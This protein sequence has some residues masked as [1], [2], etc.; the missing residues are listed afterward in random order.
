MK[1]FGIRRKLAAALGTAC[2]AAS[3]VAT[4]LANLEGTAQ[5]SVGNFYE[6]VNNGSGKCL[7][8]RSQDGLDNPGA[9]VQQYHCTGVDEQK[10]APEAAADGYY[11]LVSRRSGMCMDVRGGSVEIQQSNGDQIQ[12]WPCAATWAEQQWQFVP[13]AFL[14]GAYRLVSRVSGKCLDL[15]GG[16]TADGAKIQQWDCADVTA[17]QWKFR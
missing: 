1:N 15:S 11:L 2:I 12:Q 10:W 7:D 6:I 4:P 9:R 16:S 17:Q 3:F 13:T 5:A 14:S 8:V